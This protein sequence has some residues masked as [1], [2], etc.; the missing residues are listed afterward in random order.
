MTAGA[1]TWTD[2][3]FRPEQN[4]GTTGGDLLTRLLAAAVLMLLVAL[5][6]PLLSIPFTL[7][8]ITA[9][10]AAEA[11]LV[12]LM[13]GLFFDQKTYFAGFVLFLI[14]LA[15]L[16]LSGAGLGWIGAGLGALALADA[17]VNVYTRRCGLNGLLGISSCQC[18]EEGRGNR[19]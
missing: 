15:M 3:L 17:V 5:A 19:E 14:P 6:L 2:R 7:F 9:L 18:E 13:L 8:K 4:V 16:W 11:G 1:Q 12:F 10:I